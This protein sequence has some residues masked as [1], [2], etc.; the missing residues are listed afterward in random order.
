M[1]CCIQIQK[2]IIR[3]NIYILT[4]NNLNS[5]LFASESWLLFARILIFID[6]FAFIHY[7]FHLVWQ[8]SL[9]F[10]SNIKFL[11]L[12]FVV[13]VLVFHICVNEIIRIFCN[14]E[15]LLKNIVDLFGAL[16]VYDF[17]F[18]AIDQK[19]CHFR[20]NTDFICH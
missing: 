8:L 13:R 5:A 4:Y 2:Y 10:D 11:I 16:H 19:I 3:S 1:L 15:V 18:S 14:N 6:H 9:S 17:S 20:F 12:L 7:F